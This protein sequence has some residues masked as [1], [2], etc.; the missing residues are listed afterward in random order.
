MEDGESKIVTF[1]F[2]VSK[3]NNLTLGNCKLRIGIKNGNSLLD[4]YPI[5]SIYYG[6]NNDGSQATRQVTIHDYDVNYTGSYLSVQLEQIDSPFL[7]YESNL[8]PIIK[9]PVYTTTQDLSSINCGNTTPIKFTIT[10]SATSTYTWNIGSSWAINAGSINSNTVT[11]TPI[12]YPLNNIYVTP[13]FNGNDQ[14]AKIL[15][16]TLAPFNT[17]V[18]IVGNA[19]GCSG[20]SSSYSVN[21]GGS[22]NTVE[23][24][25]SNPSLATLNTTTGSNV[26]V[27][28]IGNG[29]VTLTATVRNACNQTKSSTKNILIGQP[30]LPNYN[31]QGGNDNVSTNSYSIL[32]I[33]AANG[34]TSYAWEVLSVNANCDGPGGLTPPG[35]YY[36][37]ITDNGY[38]S[39]KVTWGNCPGEYRVRCVASNSCASAY[40]SDKR[41]TVF[42]AGGGG[43]PCPHALAVSPNPNRKGD[44]TITV[45]II[46]PPVD[47]PCDNNFSFSK[48]SIENITIYD[49]ES[50]VIFEGKF[51][52]NEVVLNNLKLQKG[53][54]V[55]RATTN[56]GEILQEKLM[57]E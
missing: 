39:K 16:V 49:L 57:V 21:L 47:P 24:T 26:I 19:T 14:P 33:Q 22:S 10:S 1:K 9:T 34:A 8:I 48:I 13:K 50:K 54:Y 42:G 35:V 46:Q 32:T 25:V 31:I 2:T 7:K 41:V 52:S 40:Y 20:S 30:T 6:P 18:S 36:P 56:E 3:P 23:W 29:T 55:V 45:N 53:L 11:L 28:A 37:T 15:S 27:T 17:F 38:N 44:G 51:N 12:A 4:I 5:E 43:N